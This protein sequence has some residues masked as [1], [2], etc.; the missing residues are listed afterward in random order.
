M[1]RLKMLLGVLALAACGVSDPVA[2]G[3]LAGV[4][5]ASRRLQ[6]EQQATLGRTVAMPPNVVALNMASDG[7]DYGRV[8][9][10]LSA[11]G[12]TLDALLNWSKVAAYRGGGFAIASFYA[13]DLWQAATA[14]DTAASQ[15]PAQAERLAR[16]ARTLKEMSVSM[17]LYALAVV[18][19]DGLR[20]ADAQSWRKHVEDMETTFRPQFAL[21]RSMT[22][23][24]RSQHVKNALALEWT[25]RTVRGRDT[26]LC[27]SEA[28]QQKA[29]EAALAS[30]AAQTV[31]RD[32]PRTPG[33]DVEIVLDPAVLFIPDADWWTRAKTGEPALASHLEGVVAS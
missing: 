7:F 31:E 27:Q 3:P 19:Q 26:W 12:V 22:P 11:P 13:T 8:R 32:D 24:V 30:G 4:E 21:A 16:Q 14:Y 29:M 2:D 33:R 20:C 15:Q 23:E 5:L 10:L 6:L 18:E 28:I 25:T 17:A 1:K 9:Q